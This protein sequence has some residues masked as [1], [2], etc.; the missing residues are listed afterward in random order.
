MSAEQSRGSVLNATAVAVLE[1]ALDEVMRKIRHLELR[2]RDTRNDH[3]RV[4]KALREAWR[5][6]ADLLGALRGL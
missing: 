2:E 3:E 4:N 5:R 1:D 6:Q